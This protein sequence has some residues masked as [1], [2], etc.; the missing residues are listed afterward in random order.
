[1]SF[2]EREE[3]YFLK[4][5]DV[6]FKPWINPIGKSINTNLEYR[7][8]TYKKFTDVPLDGKQAYFIIAAPS[9][10]PPFSAKM[11]S[12]LALLAKLKQN[13][14]IIMVYIVEAHAD[15][16]WPLGFGVF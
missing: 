13:V 15:D 1:M 16:T 11:A 9:T 7:D 4:A 3:I 14:R 6:N 12:I 10:W 8:S 5:N 2:K